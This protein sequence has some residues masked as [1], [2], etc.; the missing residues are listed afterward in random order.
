[1]VFENRGANTR[2]FISCIGHKFGVKDEDTPEMWGEIVH[3]LLTQQLPV[4]LQGSDARAVRSFTRRASLFTAAPPLTPGGTPR[5]FRQRRKD[6]TVQDPVLV[7]TDPTRRDELIA[8]A[9]NECGHMGRDATYQRLAERVFWPNMYDSV[10]WFVRSCTSCQRYARRR[11]H[12]L[13]EKTN[14]PDRLLRSWG[15][16]V[17]HM[18][19]GV[20]EN[21]ARFL[22][23]ELIARHGSA[24]RITT[25]NG[26][27]FKNDVIKELAQRYGMTIVFSSAYHPQGNAVVERAHQTLENG[28]IK[29]AA[30]VPSRWP[31][32]LP[33]VLFAVRTT[34][35]R[36]TG[37]SPYWMTFG[38]QPAYPFDMEDGTWAYIDWH[39]VVDTE[40]LIAARARQIYERNNA[41][42]PILARLREQRE[43]AIADMNRRVGTILDFRDF[44]PGMYVLV[45]ETW[46]QN[47]HGAKDIPP[48][49]GPYIIHKQLS[50]STYQ[51]RELDGTVIRGSY[52]VH[53]LRL[54]FFRDKNQSLTAAAATFDAHFGWFQ[55]SAAL[56]YIPDNVDLVYHLPLTP[57]GLPARLSDHLYDPERAGDDVATVAAFLG[58]RDLGRTAFISA[59][60][61]MRPDWRNFHLA[62]SLDFGYWVPH[63]R[64]ENARKMLGSGFEIVASSD[65]RQTVLRPPQPYEGLVG[66]ASTSMVDAFHD[67]SPPPTPLQ[68]PPDLSLSTARWMCLNSDW[69]AMQSNPYHSRAL[70]TS[71]FIPRIPHPSS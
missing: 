19:R 3:W 10:A 32:Y 27:E 47:R 24:V 59:S 14:T 15:L 39:Q 38:I 67:A 34:A 12:M 29:A 7:I 21:V 61:A 50:D 58:L 20:A 51:L 62:N 44:K 5:L 22:M 37:V 43:R 17:I 56:P 36:M 4:R 23:E 53:R 64:V 68:P 25:D 1:P 48:W 57:H 13:Y 45:E 69:S 33:S 49:S 31:R 66:L 6:G 26:T 71:R 41:T 65:A 16:D 46:L 2:G 60:R 18:P 30:G 55:V 70:W 40:S 11:N 35:S 8:Y 63:E 28:C 9:H 42:L 54:F 52:T